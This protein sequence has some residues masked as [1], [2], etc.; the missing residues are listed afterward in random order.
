MLTYLTY[1]AL[2]GSYRQLCMLQ[3]KHTLQLLRLDLQRY[4]RSHHRSPR[5]QSAQTPLPGKHTEHT[6]GLLLQDAG[7]TL[8]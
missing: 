8:A 1:C 6:G 2:P 5:S 4:L 3:G 7:T